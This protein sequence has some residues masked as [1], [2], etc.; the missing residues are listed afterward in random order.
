MKL[1]D[2]DNQSEKVVEFLLQYQGMNKEIA[3]Q[4]WLHSKTYS[5]IYRR[6]K[7]EMEIAMEKD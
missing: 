7:N 5:E 4:T 6:Q 2:F 3:M 1:N